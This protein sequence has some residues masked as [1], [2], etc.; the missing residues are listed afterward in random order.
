MSSELLNSFDKELKLNI[1]IEILKQ[2]ALEI[3]D[4]PQPGSEDSTMN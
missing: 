3:V 1:L 4:E 2:S